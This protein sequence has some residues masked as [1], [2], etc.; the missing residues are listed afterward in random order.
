MKAY[1][2]FNVSMILTIFSFISCETNN[3]ESNSSDS[4]VNYWSSSTLIH[5]HL[6]GKVKNV[7]YG[8]DTYKHTDTY[9][10]AGYITSTSYSNE[11]ITDNY[12]YDT[13]GVLNCMNESYISLNRIY[14]T[15]YKYLNTG[16]FVVFEP[17]GLNTNGLIPNLS[18]MINSESGVTI[19][20]NFN[21]NNLLLITTYS[22]NKDTAIINYNG[23]YPTDIKWYLSN[24]LLHTKDVFYYG[25][26]MFKSYTDETTGTD[27]SNQTR[28]YFK[29]DNKFQLLDSVVTINLTQ[30]N[31]IHSTVVYTYDS[32]R[33][34]IHYETPDQTTNNTDIYD[35]T[36]VYD[37]HNNWI[38]KTT[39]S[40]NSADLNSYLEI[41]ETRTITY[42]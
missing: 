35:I 11:S 25:N 24:N 6:N 36:Y 17:F 1:F 20:Y 31:T 32:N 37:S 22:N 2:L 19:D 27:Y 40:R 29:P 28:Y 41:P 30:S 34:I 39:I 9:N 33:N 10:E 5:Q 8:I 4:I 16:K 38:S 14:P 21:G 3:I 23:Q 12:I 7:V 26:G 13:T 18:S 15:T 42:W